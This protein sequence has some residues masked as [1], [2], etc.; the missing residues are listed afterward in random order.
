MRSRI[1]ESIHR[2]FLLTLILLPLAS[3]FLLAKNSLLTICAGSCAVLTVV[4]FTV[5]ERSEIVLK[6][7]SIY[8]LSFAVYTI[9]SLLWAPDFT[10]AVKTVLPILSGIVLF[11]CYDVFYR[12]EDSANR[13][14]LGLIQAVVIIAVVESLIVLLQFFNIG[15]AFLSSA[16]GNSRVFGTLGNPNYVAEFLLAPAFLALNL[17]LNERRKQAHRLYAA[18]FLIISLG[19]FATFSRSGLLVWGGGLLCYFSLYKK[20]TGARVKELLKRLFQRGKTASAILLT[21]FT[22]IFILIPI[23]R[24]DRALIRHIANKRSIIGRIFIWKNSLSATVNNLPLGAGIGGFPST[25]AKAQY[26]H[27]NNGSLS[28]VN[29]GGLVQNAHN[30]ILQLFVELG[31]GALLFLLFLWRIFRESSRDLSEKTLSIGILTGFYAITASGFLNFPLRVAPNMLLFFLLAAL[32]HRNRSRDGVV[33]RLK[34]KKQKFRVLL[35]AMPAL[36]LFY[37][38]IRFSIASGYLH[39]GKSAQKNGETKRAARL[40]DTAYKLDSS[41]SHAAAAVADSLLKRGKI[42]KAYSVAA[43]GVSFQ[44]TAEGYLTLARCASRIGEKEIALNALRKKCYTFRNSTS[45]AINYL[46]ALYQAGRYDQVVREAG[47]LNRVSRKLSRIS[48]RTFDNLQEANSM[49]LISSLKKRASSFTGGAPIWKAVIPAGEQLLL[50][51]AGQGLYRFTPASTRFDPVAFPA[52]FVHSLMLGGKTLYAGTDRGVFILRGH[53]QKTKKWKKLITVPSAAG[54]VLAIKKALG[55]IWFLS[56][57]QI[58]AIA[59]Q[60][61]KKTSV[62]RTIAG[63][64]LYGLRCASTGF[65]QLVLGGEGILFRITAGGQTA[66]P[67]RVRELR[68]GALVSP[69]INAIHFLNTQLALLCTDRGLLTVFLKNGSVLQRLHHRRTLLDAVFVDKTLILLTGRGGIVIQELEEFLQTI[70]KHVLSRASVAY[71]ESTFKQQQLGSG[72]LNNSNSSRM[73]VYSGGLHRKWIFAA[74]QTALL[75]QTGPYGPL[76]RLN[77]EVAAGPAVYV[78][79]LAASSGSLYIFEKDRVWIRNGERYAVLRKFRPDSGPVRISGSTNSTLFCTGRELFRIDKNGIRRMLILPAP[80]T[81]ISGDARSF[82]V[83]LKGQ[84]IRVYR[85]GALVRFLPVSEPV[86]A[87]AVHNNELFCGTADRGIIQFRGN[88]QLTRT[89]EQ[90][91]LPDG[92]ITALLYKDGILYSG[93]AGGSITALQLDSGSVIAENKWKDYSGTP[94]IAILDIDSIP[95]AV[96][97][98]KLIFLGRDHRTRLELKAQESGVD[99]I[100]GAAKWKGDLVVSGKK[101]LTVYDSFSQVLK[102]FLP[103]LNTH[104]RGGRR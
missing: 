27:F 86:T 16:Q 29:N 2:L 14:Q 15:P 102:P 58:S 94:V 80:G 71:A 66:F 73:V 6:R 53:T 65:G 44:P 23:L 92:R 52:P 20:T 3:P 40:L 79:N 13:K 78:R 41:P 47:A 64:P 56:P 74:H 45:C 26:D 37:L 88:S 69:V 98:T 85:N 36:L 42:R 82:A 46:K 9:L 4:L 87:L 17:F 84:G 48:G 31:A 83:A 35:A 61:A 5:R 28:F 51:S 67:I 104:Q 30:D 76:H 18:A 50:G 19:I 32:V 38:P 24:V 70:N 103:F 68:T 62:Y 12:N 95:V 54:P 10:G 7:S 101:G 93:S 57:E 11:F 1:T 43:S 99:I 96:K 33:R 8:L 81:A 25:Y 21:G 91:G 60:S 55:K 100:S 49:A 89:G 97:K 39:A 34:L 90:E 77:P 63:R 75:S 72:L 22:I 59:S